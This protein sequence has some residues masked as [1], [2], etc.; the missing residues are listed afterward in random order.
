MSNVMRTIGP[1]LCAVLLACGTHD[2]K[3]VAKQLARNDSIPELST[4]S[5][6]PKVQVR[7]PHI[8]AHLIYD[9]G[10]LSDDVIGPEP[11]PLW[12]TIIGE[13]AAMDRQTGVHHPSEAILVRVVVTGPP[14]GTLPGAKVKLV[15]VGLGP[16]DSVINVALP[17]L[18]STGSPSG[19]TVKVNMHGMGHGPSTIVMEATLTPFDSTG[20]AWVPFRLDGT[21]CERIQLM[22]QLLTDR[23]LDSL[24]AELPFECGE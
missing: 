19:S 23:P 11:A 24:H 7:I 22:A 17:R 16:S 12:N 21:G 9:D 14:N 10:R 18:D 1:N 13:G 5:A 6:R 4:D 3:S 20:R 8:E 15:V 2:V